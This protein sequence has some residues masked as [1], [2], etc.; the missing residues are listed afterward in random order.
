M[1][2]ISRY[3]DE[4]AM[5]SDLVAALRSRG[6]KA[7]TAVDAGLIAKTDEQQLAFATESDCVLGVRASPG[8]R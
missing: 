4:D 5:D 1:S 8:E 6:V 2:L 7:E 3:I